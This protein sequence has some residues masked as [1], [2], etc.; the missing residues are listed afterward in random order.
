MTNIAIHKEQSGIDEEALISALIELGG[1]REEAEKFA[2][3]IISGHGFSMRVKKPEE[4]SRVIK[5]FGDAGVR[6]KSAHESRNS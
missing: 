2:L 6:I 3:E 4:A 5:L 1:S